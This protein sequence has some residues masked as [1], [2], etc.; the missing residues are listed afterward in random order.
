MLP[1]NAELRQQHAPLR[2]FIDGAIGVVPIFRP[3]TDLSYQS[4]GTLVVAELVQQLSGKT[5]SEFVR[6]E[7]LQPLEMNSTG[8]GSRGFNRER[9]VRVETPE[10]QA[11]SDFGW[12][13]TYWQE[14][15]VPWGGM[16]SA[17]EDFALIC[18]MLLGGGELDG[19]RILSPGTVNMMT[20]NRLND[21]PQS[22]RTHS[23]DSTLGTR[24]AAQS[25]RHI[26]QLGRRPRTECLRPHRCDGHDVL[27]R[28]GS[29]RLLPAIHLGNPLQSPLATGAS[30]E[31]GGVGV[32]VVLPVSRSL[33][34]R[35]PVSASCGDEL[36]SRIDSSNR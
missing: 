5:I 24:L 7:I 13:S 6:D 22:L 12:N 16:F 17:P 19:V 30:V 1:D 10:Y 4:M 33:R 25:P 3:G 34:D 28:P 31:H 15:G 26:R 23:P 20:T 14:L 29:R 11:G 21:Q 2:R 27:D 36:S 9:L 8:L 35:P 18:Q 32:C